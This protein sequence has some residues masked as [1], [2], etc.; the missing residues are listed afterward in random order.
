ML[1]PVKLESLNR[2][3]S[4]QA[5]TKMALLLFAKVKINIYLGSLKQYGDEVLPLL[6]EKWGKIDEQH[7]RFMAREYL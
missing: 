7:W 4:A 3:M 1:K 2:P 6:D 5:Q